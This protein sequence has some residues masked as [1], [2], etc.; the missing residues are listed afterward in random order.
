VSRPQCPHV[1]GNQVLVG[2]A[3]RVSVDQRPRRNIA[4]APVIAD[5][6]CEGGARS[7]QLWLGTCCAAASAASARKLELD[8]RERLVIARRSGLQ[9]YG[10][11]DRLLSL[12]EAAESREITDEPQ[13]PVGPRSAR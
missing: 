4:A 3:V 2:I 5:L 13:V 7:C 12:I 10:P 9:L 6:S 11:A 1:A 8:D